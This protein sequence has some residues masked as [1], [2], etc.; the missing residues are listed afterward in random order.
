MTIDPYR[1]AVV[2]RRSKAQVQPKRTAERQTPRKHLR[3]LKESIATASTQ[4]RVVQDEL[5][6]IDSFVFVCIAALRTKGGDDVGPDVTTVLG[7]AYDKLVLDVNRHI[8]D[9]LEA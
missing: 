4:L 6:Q 3:M 2:K 9:I 8:R 1:G 5:D 7:V